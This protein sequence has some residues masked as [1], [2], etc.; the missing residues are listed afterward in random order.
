[1]G[2]KFLPISLIPCKLLVCV[3]VYIF[4]YFCVHHVVEDCITKSC[5]LTGVIAVL[6][7]HSSDLSTLSHRRSLV[8]VRTERAVVFLFSCHTTH[9]SSTVAAADGLRV[10]SCHKKSSESSL[11]HNSNG[12][13]VL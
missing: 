4:L 11:Q 13:R 9:R 2:T 10:I 5:V 1:M 7:S 3:Y 6:K 12:G 8:N